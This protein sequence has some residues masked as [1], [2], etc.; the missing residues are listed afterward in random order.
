MRPTAFDEAFEKL[1][2]T[3]SS[4]DALLFNSTTLEDVWKAATQIQQA[5][6]K[7]RC[8][9][10]L[11]RLEPLLQG[12]EQYSKAIEVICNGTPYVSWIWVRFGHI[13]VSFFNL[14]IAGAQA[15]I[16]L[17]LQV[18]TVSAAFYKTILKQHSLLA[19]TP[20]SSKS[21]FAHMHK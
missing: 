21:C 18:M 8:I 15:P 7:R 17:M 4:S 13:R 20:M 10:N 19:S 12:L 16:K 6:R 14:L 2:Q 9:Q 11:R 5:Q 3:V 1:N